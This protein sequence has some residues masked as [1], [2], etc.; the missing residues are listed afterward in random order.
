M[1]TLVCLG[2]AL[3]L[4]AAVRAD[5]KDKEAKHMKGAERS[6]TIKFPEEV[7]AM[8]GKPVAE[9]TPYE[10][11]IAELAYR[12]VTYEFYR[13]DT[14]L[15]GEEKEKYLGLKKQ[16]AAFD[17][18]K[19][20]PL[21]LAMAATDLGPAPRWRLSRR[22]RIAR[23]RVLCSLRHSILPSVKHAMRT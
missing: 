14:R 21:P 13:L 17:T 18:L 9:R 8:M 1:R 20:E 7:Q 12:Q 22:G 11:Q 23:L 15:K 6:A 5:D 2:V 10:Q 4:V 16:L 19:P 3:I